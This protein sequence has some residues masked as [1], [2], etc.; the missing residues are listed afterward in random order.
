MGALGQLA[1]VALL[2]ALATGHA[3]AT[4][5]E[6]V[7]EWGILC[8]LV[9]QL[10]KVAEDSKGTA[11]TLAAQVQAAVATVAHADNISALGSLAS[12]RQVAEARAK[13]AEVLAQRL[14]AGQPPFS[15]DAI[16]V[17]AGAGDQ[18]ADAKDVERL[19][20]AT[21]R[22][23]VS[24]SGAALRNALLDAVGIVEHAKAEAEKAKAAAVAALVTKNGKNTEIAE[25][26]ATSI[27][28]N[29]DP[30]ATETGKCLANDIAWLCKTHSNQECIDNNPYTAAP[31]S[32]NDVDSNTNAA[33]AWVIL[34][35][36][37]I[38]HTPEELM[39]TSASLFAGI[40]AFRA[41]LNAGNSH[42]GKL[43]AGTDKLDYT[44]SARDATTNAPKD[45]PWE[46]E[47]KKVAAALDS[48]RELVRDAW[49]ASA[50]ITQL[51]HAL[52]L[53]AEQNIMAEDAAT[54][55]GLQAQPAAGGTPT[56]GRP[57]AMGGNSAATEKDASA[58]K[59]DARQQVGAAAADRDVTHADSATRLPR[60]TAAAIAL[61]TAWRGAKRTQQSGAQ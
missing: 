33:A 29:S 1:A 35:A 60:R 61:C 52:T 49:A 28:T 21:A 14:V 7:R 2:V 13:A 45:V 17:A 58:Q 5:K 41:A 19:R 43:G 11:V 31:L 51:A 9:Q 40:A 53:A 34:R 3:H 56:R 10:V 57:E 8:G 25:T 44:Q 50:Q 46:T 12:S 39:P 27:F 15:D 54:E 59:R 4:A 42:A 23:L 30:S 24:R 26:S 32:D 22:L 36:K 6:S 47:I 20:N 18:E 55:A 37:C 48:L 38:A 16:G